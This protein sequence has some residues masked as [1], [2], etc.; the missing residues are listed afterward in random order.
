MP[1]C[2]DLSISCHTFLSQRRRSSISGWRMPGL[3][4]LWPGK[5]LM[6]LPMLPG[7]GSKDSRSHS[8][9]NSAVPSLLALVRSRKAKDNSNNNSNLARIPNRVLAC[10]VGRERR[11]KSASE[12]EERESRRQ[13]RPRWSNLLPSIPLHL[14]SP[15][16]LLSL[17]PARPLLA[18]LYHHQPVPWWRGSRER[19]F[20]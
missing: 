18:L 9:T 11:R 20:L 4:L 10:Q 12:A 19:K 17:T 1:F 6:L 7:I 8:G 15:V 3:A 5:I 2:S 13:M 16:Q 14:Q